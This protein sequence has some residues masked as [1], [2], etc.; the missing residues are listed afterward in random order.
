MDKIFDKGLT[1][2]DKQE[3]LLKSAKNIEDKNEELL[4][5]ISATNEVSRTAKNESDF[6]YDFKYK[7]YTFYRDFEKFKRMVSIDPKHGK[8]KKFHKPLTNFKNHKP[9]TIETKSCKDRIINNV[10][11]FYKKLFDTYKK[12]YDSKKIFDPNQIKI[13]GKKKQKPKSTEKNTE[14]D[15]QKPLWFGINRKQFEELTGDF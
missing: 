3:G 7:F 1:E 8:L 10:N 14:R 5:A 9:T 13:F 6:N 11:Q 12:N 4:K 15:V 2:E